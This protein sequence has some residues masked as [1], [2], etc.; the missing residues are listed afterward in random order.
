VTTVAKAEVQDQLEK[1]RFYSHQLYYM[2][3]KKIY[4]PEAHIMY[5]TVSSFNGGERPEQGD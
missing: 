2:Y 1:N 5:L 4:E 3:H